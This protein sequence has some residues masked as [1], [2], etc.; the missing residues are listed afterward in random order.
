MRSYDLTDGQDPMTYA[1]IDELQRLL[2]LLRPEKLQ[3]VNIGADVGVSTLA[4]L[5][6]AQRYSRK[7]T[8]WSVDIG[9][10]PGELEHVR[11]AGFPEHS[12]IRLLGRSQELGAGFPYSAD[13]IF[14]DGSH[15]YAD[16]QADVDV[17]LPN[18]AAWGI[19]A[20][21][22]YIKDPPANNVTEAWA[23]VNE[24]P[25]LH[26]PGMVCLG[27]VDRLIAF[28]RQEWPHA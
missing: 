15:R 17:W 14:V 19:I 11:Q 21:H 20:F 1:E 5:E 10:C 28:Q 8:L 22:D 25:Q 6:A 27:V 26:A 13:L 24:H 7:M 2:S 12:V 18:L 16:V 23:A 4:F 3:L 9:P